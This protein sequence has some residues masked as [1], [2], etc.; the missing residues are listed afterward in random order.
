MSLLVKRLYQEIG[1]V[2]RLF[3]T[4]KCKKK[5]VKETGFRIGLPVS[6]ILTICRFR[7]PKKKKRTSLTK[8]PELRSR[9]GSMTGNV[10]CVTI[11]ST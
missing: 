5:I 2:K 10:V 4:S 1:I 6:L 9:T 3:I 8:H 11:G 7:L